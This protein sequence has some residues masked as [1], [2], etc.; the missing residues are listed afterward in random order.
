MALRAS[1]ESILQLVLRDAGV[2][3]AVGLA[4][5]M[6][7]ALIAGHMIQGLLFGVAA[8]D[9]GLYFEVIALLAA[10]A[11]ICSL[12]PAMGAARRDPA[13]QLRDL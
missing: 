11:F 6:A 13:L 8:F 4:L 3:V 9:L 10:T 5:G 1:Q 12:I 2:Q 7:L